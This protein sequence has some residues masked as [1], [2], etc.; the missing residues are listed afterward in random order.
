M[1]ANNKLP[2]S[3][4]ATKR[5]QDEAIFFMLAASDA[6]SQALAITTFHILDN[7]G[8]LRK[9]KNELSSAFPNVKNIPSLEELEPLP[10]LVRKSNC[11]SRR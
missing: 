10:Y 1:L 6:P 5:L 9:L 8:V 7:P 2:P 11:Q 3:E 4:K